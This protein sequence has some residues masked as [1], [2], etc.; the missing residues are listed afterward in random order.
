MKNL[1]LEALPLLALLAL[2]GCDGQQYVDPLAALLTIRHDVTGSKLI[3]GCS[4]VPVLLGSQVQK[5]YTADDDLSALI[6]ITRS[7]VVVTFEGPA[8]DGVEP[9][10]ATTKELEKGGAV[11]DYPPDGYTVELG[12][13]CD[14]EQ[15]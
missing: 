10:R 6:T 12:S 2:F 1:K 14:V 3:E 15:P 9:F 11:D 7:E 13:G 5:R 8:A 4:Y